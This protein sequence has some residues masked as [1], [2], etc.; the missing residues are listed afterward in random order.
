[1][2]KLKFTLKDVKEVLPINDYTSVESQVLSGISSVEEPLDSTLIFCKDISQTL[3]DVL[4]NDYNVIIF[5]QNNEIINDKVFKTDKSRLL[6]AKVL[7][8]IKPLIK[9]ESNDIHESAI[10]ED[11]V[12]LGAGVVVGKSTLI[13]SGV[14]INDNVTIG[15]NCVI[16]ENSVIG[17]QGFGVEKDK[18]RRNFKIPHV[19]GVTIGDWVEIGALNTVVSGTINPTV[20]GSYTKVDDHVHIAHN[21]KIEENCIITAGVIF[22]GSVTLGK[23]TWVGPNSTI[24]NGLSIAEDTLIGV[25]TT[26]IKDIT[27]PGETYIG[28]SGEEIGVSLDKK[29]RISSILKEGKKK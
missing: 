22:S 24:K 14:V 26:I 7:H 10:L 6:L 19:G 29:R 15:E 11:N 5:T 8:V 13:K 21:C 20:I 3:A 18:G 23:N 28:V 17:G 9:Y 27:S 2:R 25:G 12:T 4:V 1:M 16:R